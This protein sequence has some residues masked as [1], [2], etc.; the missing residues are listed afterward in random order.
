[1]TREA[2]FDFS[3]QVAIVTGAG[4]GLGHAYAVDLVRR[5]AAVV[6]N[7]IA[8]D[9]GVLRAETAAE[10]IRSMGGR[11]VASDADVATT[12]GARALVDLA[13][14][15][16]GGVSVV[17]HNAGFLRP[18]MVAD[19]TE[20]QIDSII[21]VHLTASIYLAQAAWP[22][23][24]RSNYGRIVLTSSGS[25]F[26]HMGQTNYVAAKA[27][28]IGLVRALA[29]E[30]GD[31]NIR[32]NC[33]L[34]YARSLIGVENPLPG[35]DEGRIRPVLNSMNPRRTAE[36]VVP[37]VTYLA[38]PACRV[39]GEAYSALAG[40]YAR[41][42]LALTPGWTALDPNATTAETIAEHLDEISATEG[43]TFPMSM[44]EQIMMTHRSLVE[45]GLLEPELDGAAS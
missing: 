7:D 30:A 10:E 35:A 17:I 40:T 37:M 8:R 1:M 43:A 18:N 11:A 26:G 42:P 23:M 25:S 34:P 36:S 14:A 21:A 22:H 4:R 3:G 13:L 20:D 27:G 15:E 39:N 41:V 6:V 2:D 12:S 16:F 9:D 28:V 24:E 31:T 5:G 29:L 45:Q 32:A 19:L 38:S 44:E 33:I